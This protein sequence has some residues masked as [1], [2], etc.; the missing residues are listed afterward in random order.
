MTS[1]RVCHQQHLKDFQ[2]IIVKPEF[3]PFSGEGLQLNEVH[4]VFR[5]ETMGWI[6]QS[7]HRLLDVI[8]PILETFSGN[9][10]VVD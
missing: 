6:P 7:S 4:Q 1:P 2:V 9:F 5:C 10:L 3:H 8:E